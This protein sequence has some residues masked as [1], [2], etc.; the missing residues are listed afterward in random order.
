[1]VNSANKYNNG[2]YGYDV[3]RQNCN[4]PTEAQF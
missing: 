3:S 2:K 4:T 1:M